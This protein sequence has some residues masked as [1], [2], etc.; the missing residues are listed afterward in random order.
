VA[1]LAPKL[2]A[3]E[4]ARSGHQGT[5]NIE[6]YDAFLRGFALFY[7][8][9]K[10]SNAMARQMF[11]RAIALDPNYARAY[12]WLSW[13]YFIDW[14]FQWTEGAGSLDRA[15]ETAKKAV[16]LDDSLSDAH[17]VLGW[18]SLWKKQ[19]ATA[20]AELERAVSL[21]PNSEWAYAFLAEVLNLTGRPDEAIGFVKKAM[22]LDPNY[23]PWMV[24]HLAQSYYELRRYDEAI[25]A[26]QDALHRNPNF[27][28]T[29]RLLAVVYAELGRDKEARAEVAE[30]LRISPGASLD[31]W[32]ERFPYKNSA[33]LERYISGLRKA[34]LR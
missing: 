4:Q 29:R 7:K 22:R 12:V 33:D 11:E 21:D 34:G 26:L 32:R 19:H 16:A 3:G 20:I 1:A 8:Y 27:L 9:G 28:P 30:I 13:G 6:A 25:A 18:T 31:L 15:L 14:D 17:T 5:N 24:F 23:P 2:T 10:E